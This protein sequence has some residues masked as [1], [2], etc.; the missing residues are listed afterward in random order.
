MQG[1]VG[2]D[3]M[4]CLDQTHNTLHMRHQRRLAMA[5]CALGE[6]EQLGHRADDADLDGQQATQ[7]RDH[8]GPLLVQQ[9]Q[10]HAAAG[11]GEEQPQQQ[12]PERPDVRLYLLL[13][14][15]CVLS[16]AAN[17]YAVWCWH[18]VTGFDVNSPSVIEGGKPQ[19]VLPLSM[20]FIEAV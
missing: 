4:W 11:G 12:R 13:Q 9:L 6:A 8:D 5:C 2:C 3:A 19:A 7:Q 10:V 16:A 17:T 1:F 14:R 18:C 15:M 20:T